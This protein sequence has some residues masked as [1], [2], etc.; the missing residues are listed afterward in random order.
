MENSRGVSLRIAVVGAGI[1]GLTAAIALRRAGH[2]VD[3]YERSQLANEIGA[4]IHIT[5]N[6]NSI[7]SQLG[8][9]H[10]EQGGTRLEQI[11]FYSASGGLL[12]RIDI[13]ANSHRWQK[14]WILAHR[15]HLHNQLKKKALSEDSGGVSTR[16][17]TG[18]PVISVDSLNGVIL[19]E[20]GRS[21]QADVIIGADGVHS[22]CRLAIPNHTIAPAPALFNAF[23]FLVPI[24]EVHADSRTASIMETSGS[25]D[26]YYQDNRKVVIYP[27]VRNTLLNFVCIYPAEL[28]SCVSDN[29]S[30]AGS[31][32]MLLQIFHDF[33]LPL[34]DTM[35]KCD[36]KDLKLYPL[37][38]MAT[39]P[40]YVSGRLALVGDAAHP[41]TPH[42][43]QGGAMAMEDG[44]SLGILLSQLHS[45]DEVPER[46][47]LY[48][49]SRYRRATDIQNFS[50]LVGHENN[51]VSNVSNY[52][53][54]G[55]SHDEIHA[56]SQR[57]REYQW[58]R[59][60]RCYWRQPIV[61]GPL[62]GPRQDGWSYPR[63]NGLSGALS[64]VA[65]IT[66]KTSGTLLR[67]LLPSPAYS[68]ISPDTV[69]EASVSVQSIQGLPW[70]S[71]KGYE[72]ITFRFHGVQYCRQDGSTIQGSYCPV[73]FE[74]LTDPILTGRE[75]LGWPKL[76]SDIVVQQP[77][78]AEY[79]AVV[80]W[81]RV[82]W[83]SVS[84]TT[85][86]EQAVEGPRKVNDTALPGR[87]CLLVHKY[88]PTTTD[89]PCREMADAD[90]AVLVKMSPPVVKRRL[91]TSAAR[92][93]ITAR[94]EQELPT[95]YPIVNRLAELPVFE[96][97][98]STVEVVQG[99][100]DFS[101][102]SRII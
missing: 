96:I 54:Y 94:G 41:F 87:D 19:L 25:M 7:L 101:T 57:L 6:A 32:Q 11:R 3:I 23:R 64:T 65:T 9:D 1:G 5:P 47:R 49:E 42:L 33:A 55:F 63:P 44:V 93:K 66:F 22:R 83:A 89:Q 21:V 48:S 45:T 69:A 81:N 40:D 20:N 60:A 4:A 90:Y 35:R 74:N 50:R 34:V 59:R 82:Q 18:V 56:S 36:E 26:M 8:V 51:S 72:L 13:A 92:F 100:D 10:E 88:I 97:V 86:Q 16:L 102:A 91:R 37:L 29:Y 52:L 79:H 95:L 58:Q 31:K 73:L 62:P 27:C 24:S 70:L 78:D 38:D 12:K 39:L 76:F 61:F 85:L 43:A 28:S 71:G 15:A 46:L 68:L 67:N 14:P 99:M 75:E 84:M 53:E 98:D 17:H 77:S 80:S 2:H 30:M